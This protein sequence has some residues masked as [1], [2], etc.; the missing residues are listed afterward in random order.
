MKRSSLRR[1]TGGALTLVILSGCS[2]ESPF[3]DTF[4]ADR[5]RDPEIARAD[6]PAPARS[7]EAT[8]A[9]LPVLDAALVQLPLQ[10]ANAG[11]AI[12]FLL[13]R[14]AHGVHALEEYVLRQ[15]GVLLAFGLAEHLHPVLQPLPQYV[16]LALRLL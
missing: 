6:A 11:Q 1:L 3:R 12:V 13:V 5:P 16:L 9:D 14:A 2:S 4:D 15:Q 8:T 10:L 7:H